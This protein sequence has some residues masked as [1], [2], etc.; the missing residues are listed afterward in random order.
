MKK[1]VF[2]ILGLFSLMTSGQTL[3]MSDIGETGTSGTNWTTTG[4]NPVTISATGNASINTSVIEG[5]LNTG[6][7]VLVRS[8]N[9]MITQAGDIEKTAGADATL[10]IRSEGS[11]RIN[12]TANYVSTSGKLNLV[13]WSDYNNTNGGGSTFGSTVSSIDTNGGH[14]WAG[15]SSSPAGTATWNGLTV[16]NGPSVDASSSN[17]NALDFHSVDL[18][19]GGGDA[20]FWAGNGTG[21]GLA[22]IETH[23]SSTISTGSG[24]IILISDDF[25]AVGAL[26][27]NTTGQLVLA[28]NGG[29]YSGT[30][31][32]QHGG[33]TNLN[34]LG[35]FDDIT[36]NNIASVSGLSLGFYD[37][38]NGV[39]IKNSSPVTVNSTVEITGPIT[40]YGNGIYLVG[41]LQSTGPNTDI[42]VISHGAGT[43]NDNGFIV[44]EDTTNLT[45]NGGDIILWSNAAN[46]TSGTANNEIV[47]RNTNTFSTS[48]GRIVL[49]GGLD[50]GG[51]GGTAGDGIPDGYAYRGGNAGSA[52]DIGSNVNLLSDGGDIIIRGQADPNLG[53]AVVNRGFGVGAGTALVVNSGTGTIVVDG[54]NAS[55]HALHLSY[56][57]FAMT[58][59]STATP[60]I[61]IKGE[62]TDNSSG[63]LVNFEA[64]SGA[65]LIQSTALTGGGITFEGKSTGNA[66]NAIYL[67]NGDPTS[68]LQ[69][70][71][72]VGDIDF[73]ANG[74]VKL[75]NQA[76]FVGNRTDATPIQ[77]ITPAV[78][79]SASNIL[80][81]VNGVEESNSWRFHYDTTGS[82]TYEPF[83]TAFNSAQVGGQMDFSGTL[84]ADT[85]T[86]TGDAFWLRIF[87]VSSLTGLTF[88]KEGMTSSVATYTEWP[89]NGPIAM[90]GNNIS[91]EG[92]LTS[93]DGDILLKASG[94]IVQAAGKSI[95]T[96]GADITLWSNSDDET[97]NGGYIYLQDNTSLDTRTSSDRTANNGTANDTSGG[98]ITLGGGSGTT[99]PTGYALNVAN[100]FRGGINLG[101]ESGIGARHNSNITIISGGGNISLKGRQTSVFNGDAAGINAYEGFLL[102]AGQTGNIAME[103]NVSGS[104]ASYSD[105]MNLGNYATTAG[106]TASYIRTVDGDITLTGSASDATT[107][108]RGLTLAGGGAGLFIQ[109]TGTGNIN[110][111]G[112]PGG[113]GDQYNILLIGANILANSG[114]INLTGASTGRIFNANFGSTIGYK[115]GSDVTSST[116]DI[117]VTGDHFVL[118][119]G[120]N[121]NTAG[122]LAIESFGNSFTNTFNTTQLTYSSDLTGLTIG[123]STNTSTVIFDS[124]T[125]IAGP[126]TV[127]GGDIGLNATLTATDSNLNLYATGSVTQSAA[128]TANNLAL[129]GTGNFTLQN[130]SNNIDVLAGGDAT[131]RLGDIAY[132]DADALEIGTVN[133]TGI[134]ATGTVLVET[135]TGNLTLSE[136]INTT[137]TSD[138]A[139]ILNAGRASSA[140]TATGGDIVVSAHL[141]LARDQAVSQSYSVVLMLTVQV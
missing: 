19:T 61:S 107:H 4:T 101:T 16:G 91:I 12:N 95:T 7:S 38:M 22:G 24:D 60:A 136:S 98:A 41:N 75:T 131:T 52:I 17:Q 33:G 119:S 46:R 1:I 114:D 130:S 44:L 68:T 21:S 123:K 34:M 80:M 104:N 36:I 59:A 55:D 10:T 27:L 65:T 58:S 67:G 138:D 71:S 106:G 87:N 31:T 73:I 126:I 117:T 78:T 113:S 118:S 82:F 30:I 93:T 11:G 43:G 72:N 116:S 53:G 105:G 69:I 132:R 20:L 63:I 74:I 124:A 18:N 57:N 140:G 54:K 13:F 48:G 86:G 37:G 29:S 50:D 109:S 92:N 66:N 47:L 25:D 141:S 88:G 77:G 3:T 42:V 9:G 108:S 5:Y 79:A 40:I 96:S 127:Y 2:I 139:I 76:V 125:S 39:N 6:V 110:L 8:T 120:F 85:F 62:T 14:F 102:D 26:T 35:T 97:T 23:T 128:I 129:F 32:W 89:I 135:E 51:N 94:N 134:F 70:L 49:A 137:S 122:T 100:S 81:R 83:D 45:T 64:G 115:S 111:L 99:V 112:T 103:G 15:G 90:Y 56:G 84:S 133:P 121:F 28:P